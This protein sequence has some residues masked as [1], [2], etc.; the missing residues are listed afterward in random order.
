[1][2]KVNNENSR[3]R[4]AICSK[5]KKRNWNDLIDLKTLRNI[6]IALVSLLLTLK[7]QHLFLVFI[8]EFWELLPVEFTGREQSTDK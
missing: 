5:F 2:L 6:D 7:I 3:T 4:C 8:L 1:M